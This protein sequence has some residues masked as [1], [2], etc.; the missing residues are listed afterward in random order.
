MRSLDAFLAFAIYISPIVLAGVLL[1]LFLTRLYQII[2]ERGQD[3]EIGSDKDLG[4]N[5]GN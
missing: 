1:T 4:G 2:M 5:G 3:E